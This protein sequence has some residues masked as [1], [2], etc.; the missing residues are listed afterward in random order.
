M[1]K[2]YLSPS[3]QEHNVGV[4]NYG[5]EEKRMNEIADYMMQELKN[6]PEIAVKRNI[7]TMSLYQ[8]IDDSNS[9]K[10]DLHLALHSNAGGGT[11]CEVFCVKGGT[12][13]KAAKIIYND[14]VKIMPM[15]G[16]G[17]KDGLHLAECRLTTAPV[18]LVEIGFHDNYTDSNWIINHTQLIAET[19]VKSVLTFFGIKPKETSKEY[20]RVQVGAFK[21]KINA[22]SL[23]KNLKGKGYDT[24]VKLDEGFYKVQVGAFNQKV[25]AENLAKKLKKDGYPVWIKKS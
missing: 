4:G 1:K 15:P 19:L 23:A 6:Y 12:A 14:L 11:G 10:P 7:R 25:N 20:Y 18:V 21:E 17:I 8:M 22:Q 24:L 2:L 9:F 3:L 5:T 16:R 13:E